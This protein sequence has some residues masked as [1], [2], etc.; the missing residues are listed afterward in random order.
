MCA[1]SVSDTSP[2]QKPSPSVTH[3]H[4]HTHP[5]H[6][7]RYSSCLFI[8]Q[9]AYISKLFHLLFFST[10]FLINLHVFPKLLVFNE[11]ICSG[12]QLKRDRNG[13]REHKREDINISIATGTLTM[14]F[15]FFF[16]PCL[17]LTANI[18]HSQGAYLSSVQLSLCQSH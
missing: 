13:S 3:K 2:P 12:L 14:I 18:L 17:N 11:A 7:R 15:F 1:H 9:I 8:P 4:T 10:E 5:F 6:L 16:Y